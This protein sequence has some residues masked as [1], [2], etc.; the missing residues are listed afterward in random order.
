MQHAEAERDEFW[1]ASLDSMSAHIAILNEEGTIIAVNRAWREF[2]AQNG[3]TQPD[4]CLG[5]NYLAVCEKALEQEPKIRRVMAGMRAVLDGRRKEFFA[6]YPCHSPRKKR[7]FMLR[8]TCYEGPGPARLVVAHENITAPK[9]AQLR[10]SRYSKELE[11]AKR[12]LTAQANDL[13]KAE[14]I[15]TGRNRILELIARNEILNTVLHEIAL[16]VERQQPGVSCAVVT[17]PQELPVVSATHT[18]PGERLRYLTANALS[19]LAALREDT[20]PGL[21]RLQEAVREADHDFA[22]PF[23]SVP[24]LQGGVPRG[25]LA[26]TD[27]QSAAA[28]QPSVLFE[29]A[30][31]VAAVAIDHASLY[32]KLSFQAHHDAL[33]EVPN[34]ILFHERLQQAISSGKRGNIPFGVLMLDLDR[35]KQV[36]DT[37]GHHAGDI[38]L[39]QW[40]RRLVRMTRP[41]DTV[42][43]LGSDEFVVLL[44][45]CQSAEAAETVA[46]RICL[47][48]RRPFQVLEQELQVTCSI[49]VSFFP[50]D[51]TDPVALIRNADTALYEAKNKGRNTWLRYDPVPGSA[52]NERA[53]IERC[54]RHAIC[55]DELRLH[56]QL[57]FDAYRRV[58]GVEALLR[59]NSS[60]LGNVPP[61]RFIPVAEQSGLIIPIGA[62]VLTQACSQW[63]RW[64]G[65]GFR[66]V[67][68]GVNVS[69]LQ[70]CKGEFASTVARILDETGMEPAHL[71]LEVAESSMMN[72]M[73]EAITG[74]GKLR[75][76]GVK[77]SIDDF[78]T[79]YSSL[80]YLQRLPV[81]AVKIDRSF[82]RDL[83]EGPSNA[84]SVVQAMIT[85]ARNLKL[86]VVAEGVETEEQLRMLENLKC[87]VAQGYLLHR[88]HAPAAVEDILREDARIWKGQPVPELISGR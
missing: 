85:L 88:P 38:L 30:A 17:R 22:N 26:I 48:F 54:L 15:E 29:R 69:T 43:R 3:Q 36:N 12:L 42:A 31:S 10:A 87:D 76:L 60:E 46:R 20:A 86:K 66:A 72:D 13:A 68:M 32:E 27:L 44:N 6:S 8:V 39:R 55:K 5:V 71:E 24:I 73:E 35:F 80:S 81:D 34:R 84:A 51:G 77:V 21:M 75:A 65:A 45:R 9:A 61:A 7:W 33:T 47:A 62:W 23:L 41:S 11:A 70:L 14:A 58:A 2:A 74:I 64:Q 25:Y 67:R 19:M 59:W 53:E 50:Q 40:A 79:G 4:A 57:Q 56:Y 28:P 52:V 82:I 49:G 37:Y 78:G 83:G 16:L 18:M 63:K 1:R